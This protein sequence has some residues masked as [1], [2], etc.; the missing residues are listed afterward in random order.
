[1]T[2]LMEDKK[3]LAREFATNS[4]KFD[5][6]FPYLNDIEFLKHLKDVYSDMKQFDICVIID[7]R[8]KALTTNSEK[9]IVELDAKIELY[10]QVK[11]NLN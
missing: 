10:K 1:M 8:I 9:H 11:I 7:A 3:K 5:S 4:R 6:N 2:R